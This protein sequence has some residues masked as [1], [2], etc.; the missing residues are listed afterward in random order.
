[1]EL[2][3]QVLLTGCRCVELDCWDGDDGYPIIYHGHT[4]TS[5]IPFRA[6]VDAINKSA[7]VASPY[8]VILSIEN[9]CSMQQQIRMAQIFQVSS[10]VDAPRRPDFD[11]LTRQWK[12]FGAGIM[13]SVCFSP[14]TLVATPVPLMARLRAHQIA[15]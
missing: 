7:F 1:V 5:K 8:P 2:Y 12:M 14:P 4:F 3:S 10:Q 13:D 11:L 9:H 6:V 15:D